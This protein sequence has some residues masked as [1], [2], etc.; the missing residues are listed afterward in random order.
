MAESTVEIALVANAKRLIRGFKNAETASKRFVGVLDKHQQKIKRGAMVATAALTAQIYALKKLGDAGGGVV[1]LERAFNRMAKQA[2]TTGDEVVAS[3]KAITGALSKRQIM[4]SANTLELLGVGMENT[5]RMI[6][7]ARAAAIGLNK[8]LSFMLESLATGT[9]RQSKLFLDN[10]G[11]IISVEDAN[12]AYARTLGKTA[13]QLT[14]NERRAAFLHATLEKGGDIIEK[15]GSDTES[16][17]EPMQT[18]AASIIDAKDALA[19]A[20]LP[21]INKVVP[22]ITRAAEKFGEWSEKSRELLQ[23]PV[24][25]GVGGT[26]LIAGLMTLG[27]LLPS[28]TTA[29]TLLGVRMA[30]VSVAASLFVG[31]LIALTGIKT[32]AAAMAEELAVTYKGLWQQFRQTSD[33]VERLTKRIDVETQLGNENTEAFRELSVELGIAKRRR[34]EIRQAMTTLNKLLWVERD[35]TDAATTS[36]DALHDAH[37]RRYEDYK[38]I[39]AIIGVMNNVD[40]TPMLDRWDSLAEKTRTWREEMEETGE[41]VRDVSIEIQEALANMLVQSVSNW[42]ETTAQ[43]MASGENFTRSMAK[44]YT[45]GAI[46]M[47]RTAIKLAATEIIASAI[48][49]KAKAAIKSFFT[50]GV[51]LAAIPLIAAAAAAGMGALTALERTLTGGAPS[52]AMGGT[53]QRTGPALVHEGEV[54]VNPRMPQQGQEALAAAGAG[55]PIVVFNNYGTISGD[56]ATAWI[57]RSIAKAIRGAK[58]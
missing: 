46:H 43:L 44:A 12:K 41:T 24:G 36:T 29:V 51:S 45:I 2:G 28:I 48:A 32:N 5:A 21:A 20:L 14:D 13:D 31:A 35:A 4:E 42:M 25:A 55:G 30:T 49:E 53:V 26:A 17:A 38:R 18:L 10:L 34:E 11:I 6:E 58:R 9:A 50:G 1:D 47:M 56:D 8:P 23:M 57:E 27:A 40:V 19:R 22:K 54:I 37:V 15:V 39:I 7:I 52:F 33:E 16:A 3:A